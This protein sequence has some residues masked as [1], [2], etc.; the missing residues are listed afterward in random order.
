MKK[1]VTVLALALSVSVYG[2]DQFQKEVV[3]SMKMTSG[4]IMQLADA[5]PADMYSWAPEEGVRSFRD[6]CAHVISTNYFFAMKIGATIPEGVDMMTVES[7][8]KTKEDIAAGLKQSYEVI[9]GAIEAEKT[10]DLKNKV[11]FP[12]PGEYTEMTAILIAMS[13]SDEHLGQ[14]IAY[15]RSN[16]ITPPW[17]KK[18]GK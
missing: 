4:K 11:E 15:S 5:V 6:V 13:H 17:S 2:Q 18:D 10:K 3:G 8:L 16:G 9:L 14:L 12:F 7:D 1:I